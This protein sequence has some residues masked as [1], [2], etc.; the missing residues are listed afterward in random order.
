MEEQPRPQNLVQ[1][2]V[3]HLAERITRLEGRL[4]E[5]KRSTP[6]RVTLWAGPL[7]LVFAILT[8]A[9]QLWDG[10]VLRG[11][12]AAEAKQRDLN[13]HVRRLIELNSRI[14]RLQSKTLGPTP[15]PMAVEEINLEAVSKTCPLR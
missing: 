7:A 15:D 8:G 5:D 4:D 9:F 6:K 1:Q 10:L 11:Q 14:F 3:A 13:S 12:G 2:E